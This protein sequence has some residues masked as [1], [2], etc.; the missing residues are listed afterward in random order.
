M[1]SCFNV[2]ISSALILH[3]L[4]APKQSGHAHP[5]DAS[6]AA[7]AKAQFRNA[8]AGSPLSPL[9]PK[10][11]KNAVSGAGFRYLFRNLVR[12]AYLKSATLQQSLS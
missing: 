6:L 5:P 11:C 10:P 1:P 7:S 4:N 2:P 12:K 8:V 3:E 9:S